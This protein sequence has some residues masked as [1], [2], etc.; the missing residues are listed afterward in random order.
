[1][2]VDS[3]GYSSE[4]A[5]AGQF[6]PQQGQCWSPVEN[7]ATHT[8]HTNTHS[9]TLTATLQSNNADFTETLP[10]HRT[11]SFFTKPFCSILPGSGPNQIISN[12]TRPTNHAILSLNGGIA[13]LL[14][15]T[16]E[17]LWSRHI[18]FFQCLSLPGAS[19]QF[20]SFWIAFQSLILKFWVIPNSFLLFAAAL[21]LNGRIAVQGRRNGPE[22]SIF[23]I[24]H[25]EMK[26]VLSIIE[27]Y[28]IEKR[29]KIFT[30]AYGHGRQC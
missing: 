29:V 3:A 30:F 25:N 19:I 27:S 5:P 10:S 23:A 22:K 20:F 2:G 17:A 24:P 26:C 16:M 13:D 21:S 15:S 4:C 6:Q 12:R 7:H 1:M 28:S 18:P 8:G 11:L 14:G 9:R